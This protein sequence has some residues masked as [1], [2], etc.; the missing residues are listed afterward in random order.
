MFEIPVVVI[1]FVEEIQ[2]VHSL[3][4]TD[5]DCNVE[6]FAVH[7]CVAN[8]VFNLVCA[9]GIFSGDHIPVRRVSIYARHHVR[10]KL[11]YLEFDVGA[12]QSTGL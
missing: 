12:F 5:P 4:P 2:L 1:G 11:E 10:G 3:D 9:D 8:G 6:I 7:G